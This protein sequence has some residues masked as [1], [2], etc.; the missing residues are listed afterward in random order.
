MRGREGREGRKEL[1]REGGR[2]EQ[3]EG[4]GTVI[5]SQGADMS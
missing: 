3:K 2:E 4:D 5:F 1:G